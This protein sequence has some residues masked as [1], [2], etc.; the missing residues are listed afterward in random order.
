MILLAIALLLS[1]QDNLT[2]LKPEDK[3][4]KMLEEHLLAECAKAF[5]ARRKEIDAIKTPP[6]STRYADSPRDASISAAPCASRFAAV[7][8]AARCARIFDASSLP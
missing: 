2:V 6:T 8:R 1:P 3:P 5:D 7:A 4:K